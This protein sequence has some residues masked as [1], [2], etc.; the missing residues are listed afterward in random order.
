MNHIKN[1]KNKNRKSGYFVKPQT[2]QERFWT[3]K[4][5]AVIYV[6]VSSEGQ[7]TGWHGLESQETVCRDWCEKQPW[8]EI[9]VVKVFREEG[10]SWKQMDRKAMNEAIRFLEKENKKFTKIHYF[11]VT[12]AD[13][14]ARPDDIAEAFILEQSIEW[15]GVKIITVNNKRDVE[16]DEG[17]FLHTI[18]YAVAGLERRKILRRTMNGKLSSLKN[19]GRPFPNPPVGYIREKQSDRWYIDYIDEI[20]WPIIKEGLENYAYNPLYTKSQLYKFRLEKWLQ[21]GRSK[22][23]LYISFIE[24]TFR[25]Y[26]LYYY[27]G[28]VY[29]PEWEI[30]TPIK[31]KH[32]P[33]VSLEVIERIIEKEN[34]KISKWKSPNFDDNLKKHPLKWMITCTWC[35]RKFGCY[36]SRGKKGGIYY[37]YECGNKYCDKRIYVRKE[38]MESEFEQFIWKMKLPK[39]VYDL[40]KS[41]IINEREKITNTKTYNLPQIQWQLLS[42]QTKMKKIEDKVITINN[43]GLILKL[44]GEWSALETLQKDLMKKIN[45]PEDDKINLEKTLSEAEYIFTDPEGIWKNSNFE[46]RQSLFRVRFGWVLYYEKN[47]WLRTPETTGMYYLFSRKWDTH[48]HDI[49]KGGTNPNWDKLSKIELKSHI[50]SLIA[51]R[52]YIYAIYRINEIQGLGMEK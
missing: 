42:I 40:Y 46:I 24:K 52:E 37:Y 2:D 36:A 15:L 5:K 20:K 47:L 44:E 39:S 10:V 9:E 6:R 18:Q 31:W 8:L 17:K 35:G 33:L 7:V 48:S 30:T 28:Y 12:D 25:D 43:E 49:R 21:T 29:Y 38:L 3:N 16:T 41:T 51:Q 50:N 19:G 26:R 32:E 22:E 11:V 45:H 4:L 23:R 14:I 34:H 27:A 1:L 13:R